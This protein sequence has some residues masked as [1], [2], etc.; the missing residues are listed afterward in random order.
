[1]ALILIIIGKKIKDTPGFIVSFDE[2][3]ETTLFS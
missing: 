2:K 1:M 3:Y